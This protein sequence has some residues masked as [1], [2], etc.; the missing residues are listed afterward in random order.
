MGPGAAVDRWPRHRLD[1]KSALGVE[2]RSAVEDDKRPDVLGP[3]LLL[4]PDQHEIRS[5]HAIE[6]DRFVFDVRRIASS[7][8]AA[9]RHLLCRYKAGHDCR[10]RSVLP[11][12]DRSAHRPVLR[13]VDPSATGGSSA[14]RRSVRRLCSKNRTA[15]PTAQGAHPDD[16]GRRDCSRRRWRGV[17]WRRRELPRTVG[18]VPTMYHAIGKQRGTAGNKGDLK[19][20]RGRGKIPF[21]QEERLDLAACS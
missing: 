18:D 5:G 14:S 2:Q 6:P 10:A 13:T 20:L 19:R 9:G 11:L 1:Q 7:L 15:S 12:P 16:P 21:Y 3:A 17:R 8:H 4:R